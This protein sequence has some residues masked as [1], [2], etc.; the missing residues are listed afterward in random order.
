MGPNKTPG[1]SESYA[2][3]LQT[4]LKFFII[5]HSSTIAVPHTS[6]CVECCD[7]VRLSDISAG[8]EGDTQHTV[9]FSKPSL[10]DFGSLSQV[11]F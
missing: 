9:R 1:A 10:N 3:D 6:V 2:V 4:A 5:H 8:A 7:N 11:K